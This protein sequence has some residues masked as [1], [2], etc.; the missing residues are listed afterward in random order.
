MGDRAAQEAREGGDERRTRRRGV[1]TF[2][3]S[4]SRG[5]LGWNEE[6]SD[7]GEGGTTRTY[8][9]TLACFRIA[10]LELP[11]VDLIP[12]QRK[13]MGSS[14]DEATG[15]LRQ[16][17]RGASAAAL[18]ALQGLLDGLGALAERSGALALDDPPEFAEAV[19]ACGD[20]EGAV[21]RLV[22]GPPG[23][24]LLEQ[25]GTILSGRGE[26]LL[27]SFNVGLAGMGEKLEHGLLAPEQTV[28]L[29]HRGLAPVETLSRRGYLPR[30]PHSSRRSGLPRRPSCSFFQPTG[31]RLRITAVGIVVAVGAVAFGGGCASTS[32]PSSKAISAP[33][34]SSAERLLPGPQ[35][36]GLT[37]DARGGDFTG[38]VDD[39]E[40]KVHHNWVVPTYFG[41]GGQ[42]EF[43]FFVEASGAI[44]ALEVLESSA[45]EALVEAAREAL[46]RSRFAPLP[47]GFDWSGVSVR[48]TCVYGPPPGE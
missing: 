9:H 29:V 3:H 15:E 41:Y 37:L 20:D 14:L 40:Q 2:D 33:A 8:R 19:K 27:V 35:L 16:Q 21:R 46:T 42:V 34:S 10:G 39:F 23:A 45:S 12:N 38:W 30:P 36:R 44:S 18:G 47:E 6:A 13:G 43:S 28:Q 17:G 24:G 22:S 1:W 11:A 32:A 7:S 31:G 4:Q 26:W 48:I 25:K 5:Y